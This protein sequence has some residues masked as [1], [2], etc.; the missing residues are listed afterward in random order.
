VESLV[1]DR[2]PSTSERRRCEQKSASKDASRGRVIR[3]REE[4][5][6]LPRKTAGLSEKRYRED[7]AKP[8]AKCELEHS[9]R[10]AQEHE[11]EEKWGIKVQ[12]RNTEISGLEAEVEALKQELKIS[13]QTDSPKGTDPVGKSQ[14][15]TDIVKENASLKKFDSAKRHLED[16]GAKYKALEMEK[17]VLEA[18]L[19]S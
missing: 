18:K 16:G 12:K 14:S 4:E 13:Q 11:I 3:E 2:D 9:K 15:Y 6:A 19:T 1:H 8:D 17:E 10:V 5:F 7:L